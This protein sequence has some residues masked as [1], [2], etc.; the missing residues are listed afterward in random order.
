M[1]PDA[2]AMLLDEEYVVT[3]KANRMGVQLEGKA[4]DTGIETLLSEATAHGAI[5][6]PPSGRP[7][8]LLNVE[9]DDWTPARWYL[10]GAMRG[11][12]R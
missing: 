12:L 11:C 9:Q 10:D 7:V 2:I 3:S 4:I 5:Q 8:V 1:K 6:I